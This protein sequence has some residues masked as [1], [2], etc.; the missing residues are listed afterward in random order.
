MSLAVLPNAGH[1]ITPAAVQTT[2]EFF[3]NL[4]Q[5]AALATRDARAR[6]TYDALGVAV[7]VVT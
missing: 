4:E 2:I 5:G 7:I 3:R 1:L 6:G